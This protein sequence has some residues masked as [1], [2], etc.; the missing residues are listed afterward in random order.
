MSA[1]RD[2][3]RALA[4]ADAALR[5]AVRAVEAR[6]REL[7]ATP[8]GSPEVWGAMARLREAERAR[9]AARRASLGALARAL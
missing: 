6:E 4:R 5:D 7:R 1:R 8:T 9:D 3:E 2:A